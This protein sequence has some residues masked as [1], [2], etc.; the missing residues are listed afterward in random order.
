MTG[1]LGRQ[2]VGTTHLSRTGI[3]GMKYVD[4]SSRNDDEDEQLDGSCEL[5][6]P[7][8]LAGS[9]TTSVGIGLDSKGAIRTIG[10]R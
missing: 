4:S 10:H 7:L 6:G 1:Q 9:D 8:W 5:E 2:L 3:G